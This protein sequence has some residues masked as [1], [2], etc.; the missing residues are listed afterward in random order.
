MHHAE[1][2]HDADAKLDA[3][4]SLDVVRAV[5]AAAIAATR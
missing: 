5:E 4:L 3:F 1:H 2:R